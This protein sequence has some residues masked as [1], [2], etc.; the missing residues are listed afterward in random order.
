MLLNMV[1]SE[2]ILICMNRERLQISI[3]EKF[4]IVIHVNAAKDSLS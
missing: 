1:G 4:D 3:W 2:N